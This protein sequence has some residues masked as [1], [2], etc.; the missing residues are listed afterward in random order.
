MVGS[1]KAY[2]SATSL[3][4]DTPPPGASSLTNTNTTVLTPAQQAQQLLTEL[5]TTHRFR[6]AIGHEGPLLKYLTSHP[7]GGW[8]PKALLAKLRSKQ[9]VDDQIFAELGP[10]HVLTI[11]AGPQVLGISL[12][13]PT[14]AVAVGTLKALV[15]QF[16]LER[17]NLDV[18]RAQAAV[19]YFQNQVNAATAGLTAA[20]GN[21]ASG[22]SAGGD[23]H[24]LAQAERVAAAR[25]RTATRSFNQASL[26]L[27]ASRGEQ[28]IFR[29]IDPIKLPAKAVTGK[30][31][32]LF[33]IVAGLFVGALISFLGIV[34]VSNRDGRSADESHLRE[35]V[36]R[37]HE[38][39]QEAGLATNGSSS[40]TW[41]R[42]AERG[43]G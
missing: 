36:I 4:V 21:L 31:K 32:T 15:D 19:T 14:P 43:G 1:P 12:Q 13:G 27:A 26:N 41:A 39:L 35:A 29:V 8:G 6:V 33:G 30:K 7:S 20:K 37:P 5:L 24:A 28:G 3:W 23:T 18:G 34:A 10:K 17:R 25:L 22:A 16:N 38:P 40:E 11:I 42:V 2:E 9:S